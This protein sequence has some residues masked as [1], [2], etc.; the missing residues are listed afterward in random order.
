VITRYRDI[1][2]SQIIAD[3]ARVTRAIAWARERE[4]D[5]DE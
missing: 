1:V 4:A 3:S 5:I 2:L